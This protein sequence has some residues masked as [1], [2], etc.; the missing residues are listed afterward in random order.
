[1]HLKGFQDWEFNLDL[2]AE[3]LTSIS[4]SIFL[5]NLSI[6]SLLEPMVDQ[7]NARQANRQINTQ[8]SSCK[9][10]NE[11][12]RM[13]SR[14]MISLVWQNFGPDAQCLHPLAWFFKLHLMAVTQMLPGII[15]LT[16]ASLWGRLSNCCWT[17]DAASSATYNDRLQ[18]SGHTWI[19]HVSEICNA[20]QYS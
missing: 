5:F 17:Y 11:G 15:S 3:V 2:I 8:S 4:H 19:S 13:A 14:N 9:L 7:I 1:M 10:L 20:A 6:I 16:L 18:V 12:L